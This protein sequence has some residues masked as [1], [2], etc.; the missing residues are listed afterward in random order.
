M[1]ELLAHDIV[2]TTTTIEL[3]SFHSRYLR[4]ITSLGLPTR[5]K[6]NPE[7]NHFFTN[8]LQQ[9]RLFSR[10]CFSLLAY[11]VRRLESGDTA[12]HTRCKAEFSKLGVF[13]VREGLG[14]VR[15]VA[16]DGTDGEDNG[17]RRF[18]PCACEIRLLEVGEPVCYFFGFAVGEQQADLAFYFLC[19]Y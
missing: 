7:R 3:V 17:A 9:L 5:Q 12:V 19:V 4:G 14:R 10:Q 11:L 1:F 8:Q 18:V 16:H 6:R 15:V 2:L 13:V